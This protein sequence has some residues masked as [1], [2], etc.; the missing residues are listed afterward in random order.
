MGKPFFSLQ[1][2]DFMSFQLTKANEPQYIRI[3]DVSGKYSISRST[4]ERAISGGDLPRVKRGR[5]VLLDVEAV[6]AWI[7]GKSN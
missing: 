5:I 2:E 3:N 4:I 6:E 7:H 1:K